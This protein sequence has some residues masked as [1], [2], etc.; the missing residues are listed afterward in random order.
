M[1]RKNKRGKR[2]Q[3]IQN[4]VIKNINKVKWKKKVF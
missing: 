1:K 2:K 3:E 4:E